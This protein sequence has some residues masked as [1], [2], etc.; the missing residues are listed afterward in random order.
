MNALTQR[1]QQLRWQKLDKL[2]ALGFG[3][4]DPMVML[5]AGLIVLVGG[6]APTA[7]AV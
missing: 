5:E 2:S 1:M 3:I 6:C 4:A 7:D